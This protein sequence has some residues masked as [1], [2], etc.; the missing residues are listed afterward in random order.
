MSETNTSRSNLFSDDYVEIKGEPFII[1]MMYAQK[2][3][4]TGVDVYNQIGFG[5]RAF[6]HKNM[7]EK[8]KK[9]IPILNQKK[10]K[11]KIGDAYRP[12]IAHKM[13]KE[14]IPTEGFFATN[15]ERSQHCH[16]TAIDVCLCY[17]DGTELAYPTKMDAYREDYA[18]QVQNG[19]FDEFQ[20]YLVKARHDY[21]DPTIAEAIKNREAL[22]TLMESL[23]LE[24]IPF[25]WWHYDLPRGREY[26]IPDFE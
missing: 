13:L 14:I 15:P 2:N 5:N 1:E 19:S 8:L 11:M 17:E 22:K 26:P 4:M 12:T 7:W 6:V 21:Q 23:G 3:N 9:L 25:E 18:K 20:K 24:S 16:A 10:L